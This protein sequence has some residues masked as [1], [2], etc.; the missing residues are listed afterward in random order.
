MT[1]KEGKTA[2]ATL[3]AVD[4]SINLHGYGT[5]VQKGEVLLIKDRDFGAGGYTF[6]NQIGTSVKVEIDNDRIKL[7]GMEYGTTRFDLVDRRG[8]V[9]P[10]NVGVY[11]LKELTSSRL[12]MTMGVN[13]SVIIS[14]QYGEGDWEIATH[15]ES[16]FRATMMRGSDYI[17]GERNAL[18]LDT[19]DAIGQGHVILKD[20]AGYTA[21]IYVDVDKNYK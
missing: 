17:P 14:I 10:M 16:M 21:I 6:R 9:L 5:S 2:E 3:E 7:T 13:Q 15:N 8:S 4:E 18:Q 19:Y 20:K 1:D 11:I 12:D